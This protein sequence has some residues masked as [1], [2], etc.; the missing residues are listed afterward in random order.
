VSDETGRIIKQGKT[1]KNPFDSFRKKIS[2]SSREWSLLE[3][4]EEREN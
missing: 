1:G 2:S 4:R 3:H